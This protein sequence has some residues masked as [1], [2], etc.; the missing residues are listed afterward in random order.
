MHLCFVKKGMALPVCKL[1]FPDSGVYIH[2]SEASEDTKK[3]SRV[4]RKYNRSW[5]LYKEAF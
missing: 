5:C 3:W 2:S 4:S 1:K